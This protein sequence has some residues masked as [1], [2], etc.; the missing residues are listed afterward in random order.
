MAK[1]SVNSTVMRDKA[2]VLKG[3]SS[4]IKNFT[5]EMKSEIDRLRG[6]WEGEVAEATVRKFNQLND[7]FEE[8]YNTINQYAQFLMNAAD[9]WDNTNKLNMQDIESQYS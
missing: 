5:E 6:T 8:R 7:D 9:E 4:S 3:C 1:I 2:E